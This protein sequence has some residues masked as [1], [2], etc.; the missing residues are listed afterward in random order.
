ML[1]VE[2]Y[3]VGDSAEKL[4]PRLKNVIY[5]KKNTPSAKD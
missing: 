5:L 4:D 2:F 1:I 3:S